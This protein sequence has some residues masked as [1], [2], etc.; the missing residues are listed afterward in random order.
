MSWRSPRFYISIACHMEGSLQI[1][2][3]SMHTFWALSK[4]S[5]APSLWRIDTVTSLGRSSQ[6]RYSFVFR[7]LFRAIVVLG[8]LGFGLGVS[9]NF[10]FLA[11]RKCLRIK[12]LE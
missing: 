9:E 8:F 6:F 10:I 4:I 5:I 12:I 3:H 11:E 7:A 1:L 2:R